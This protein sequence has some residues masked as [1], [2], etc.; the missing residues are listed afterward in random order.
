MVMVM[1]TVIMVVMDGIT[2]IHKTSVVDD[3]QDRGVR[4]YSRRRGHLRLRGPCSQR[5]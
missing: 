4:A 3:K 2:A 5:C 1:V